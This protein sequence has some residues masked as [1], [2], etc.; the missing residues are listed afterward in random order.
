MRTFK[1]PL[2]T[3]PTTPL[4]TIQCQPF[5]ST[6]PARSSPTLC[7]RTTAKQMIRTPPDRTSSSRRWPVLPMSIWQT[8]QTNAWMSKTS[9]TCHSLTMGTKSFN[10]IKFPIQSVTLLHRC[11]WPSRGRNLTSESHVRP[12]F[13]CFQIIIGS[14]IVLVE[15]TSPRTSN[16]IQTSSSQMV[17]RTLGSQ[18]ASQSTCISNCHSST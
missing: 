6:S 17:I 11:S 16:I 15:T 7:P 5:L 9:M 13:I 4:F 2:S 10:A 3:I 8:T 14:R 1:P 18:L 12:T